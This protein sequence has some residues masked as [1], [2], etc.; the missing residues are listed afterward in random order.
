MKR[1]AFARGQST[2]PVVSVS[3]ALALLALPDPRPS[4]AVSIENVPDDTVTCKELNQTGPFW[5]GYEYRR[6]QRIALNTRSDEKTTIA[7]TAAQSAS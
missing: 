4:L 7:W 5:V 2:M 1:I 3:D 6:W